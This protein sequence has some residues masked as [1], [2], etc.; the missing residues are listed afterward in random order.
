MEYILCSSITLRKINSVRKIMKKADNGIAWQRFIENQ[1]IPFPRYKYLDSYLYGV[2]KLGT[3]PQEFKV[4]FDTSVANFWIPS[5]HRYN[6]VSR[7]TY[8]KYIV[9]SVCRS[10]FFFTC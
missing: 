5:I 3:P 10:V 1:S 6:T 8:S 9:I 2:I 4:I 7:E